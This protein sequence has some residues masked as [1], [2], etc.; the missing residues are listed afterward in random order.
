MK[1]LTTLA[2]LLVL[3]SIPA[4]AG[5]IT[6]TGVSR[7]TT[8]AQDAAWTARKDAYNRTQCA[9]KGLSASC[10]QAQFTAAGGTG[11]IYE[12]ASATQNFA[13]DVIFNL[14]DEVTAQVAAIERG[15]AVNAWNMATPAQ[16]QAACQA[17]GKTAAC[18]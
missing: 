17:L 15:D 16:R 2:G 1:R 8:A 13:L 7:T 11:T 10:T 9:S 12:G 18:Q 4:A 5:T 6:V 14:V 3:A